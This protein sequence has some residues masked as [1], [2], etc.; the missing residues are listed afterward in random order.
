MRDEIKKRER[1]RVDHERTYI[2]ICIH[3]YLCNLIEGPGLFPSGC[4]TLMT[5]G[6]GRCRYIRGY[7]VIWGAFECYRFNRDK[8]RLERYTHAHAHA[9]S[10]DPGPLPSVFSRASAVVVVYACSIGAACDSW[11]PGVGGGVAIKERRREPWR[12]VPRLVQ[13]SQVS[14]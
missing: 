9:I 3:T 2:Y 6:P 14:G 11:R 8:L 1:E 5:D 10:S 13:C 7:R 12:I 4:Q